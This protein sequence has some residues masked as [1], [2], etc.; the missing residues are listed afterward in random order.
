MDSLA[1]WTQ[2]F[3]FLPFPFPFPFPPRLARL[4]S[5]SPFRMRNLC[6]VLSLLAQV[7]MN[8]RADFIYV[9]CVDEIL[10]RS[11]ALAVEVPVESLEHFFWL[12]F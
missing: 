1:A 5:T 10:L 2:R 9:A 4:I 8:L 3:P 7:S 6:S 11:H 12:L